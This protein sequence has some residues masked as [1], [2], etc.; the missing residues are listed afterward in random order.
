MYNIDN[1]YMKVVAPPA[2]CNENTN[3]AVAGSRRLG[4]ILLL[5]AGPGRLL[6]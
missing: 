2:E 4:R 1:I 3:P 5:W 6:G